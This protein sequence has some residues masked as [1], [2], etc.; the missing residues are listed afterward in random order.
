[1]KRMK[2]SMRKKR[3]RTWMRIFQSMKVW[4]GMT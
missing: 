4:A 1:M 3:T 2:I